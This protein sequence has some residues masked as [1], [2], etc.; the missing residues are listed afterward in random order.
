MKRLYLFLFQICFCSYSV[1]QIG[2]AEDSLNCLLQDT[3]RDTIESPSTLKEIAFEKY[4]D[5]QIPKAS[6]QGGACWDDYLFVGHDRNSYMDIYDLTTK[7]FVCS[8]TLL[9]PDPVSR[10]HANTINFGGHYYKVGDEFPLLYVSSGYSISNEVDQCNTYV[11]RITKSVLQ[12]DSIAFQSD[13]VQTIS[14]IDCGG[15]SESILDNEH[16]VMW[17]RYDRFNDRCYLKYPIPDIEQKNI[18]LNPQLNPAVD[19]IMTKDFNV[20]GHNQGYLCH[21]GYFYFPAGVPA[22]GEEP[23]LGII[24]L[25]KKD[26][27][28]IVNLYDLEMY[29]P[30]NLRD[31]TWEP[32]FFFTY[33]GDFFMGYRSSVYKLNMDLVKKSNFFYNIN[34]R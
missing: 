9:T 32:E 19:T 25:D 4:M 13:L 28:Y 21:N 10:C 24:N 12:K 16:N 11:Y 26:Y 34:C 33:K 7:E 30:L 27:E 3:I 22:W 18:I 1:A 31:N 29:N 5:L 20:L 8:M 6:V 14:V 15:W 23:Y 17:I 2:L